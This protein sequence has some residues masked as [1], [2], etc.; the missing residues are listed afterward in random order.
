MTICRLSE[1][2][3]RSDHQQTASRLWCYFTLQWYTKH[4]FTVLYK[5]IYFICN[6]LWYSISVWYSKNTPNTLQ[7]IRYKTLKCLI[8]LCNLQTEPH[9]WL[10]QSLPLLGS[11]KCLWNYLLRIKHNPSAV[12]ASCIGEEL[13]PHPVTDL[14]SANQQLRGLKGGNYQ[15]WPHTLIPFVTDLYLHL[16]VQDILPCEKCLWGRWDRWNKAT[17]TSSAGL[18]ALQRNVCVTSRQ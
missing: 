18:E 7:C 11:G 17:S 3:S 15:K 16:S 4:L 8:I 13:P 1:L 5:Q 10:F 2:T 9:A 14:M 12:G 6:C